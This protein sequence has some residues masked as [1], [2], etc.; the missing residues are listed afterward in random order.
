M[1][2]QYA[3]NLRCEAR[4]LPSGATLVTDAPPDNN[5]LGTSFSPTDLLATAMGT[6]VLTVLAIAGRGR[7][8]ELGAGRVDVRKHMSTTSPRRIARLEVHLELPSDVPAE[9]R[10]SLERA[11]SACP[12]HQSVSEQMEV[13]LRFAYTLEP[14][15]EAAR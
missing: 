6:C 15:G 2:I 8:Y 14:A 12:V 1:Q 4:H 11:A 9:L 5:G 7:G 3:G 13:D 10:A